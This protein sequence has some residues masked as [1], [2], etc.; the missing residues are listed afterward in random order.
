[1]IQGLGGVLLPGWKLETDSSSMVTLIYLRGP[2]REGRWNEFMVCLSEGG[3]TYWEAECKDD[4]QYFIEKEI[5]SPFN[6][7]W[8]PHQY[9]EWMIMN[10][11]LFLP[12]P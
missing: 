5:E 10:L 2:I 6:S 9:K 11:D 12:K 8:L 4:D 1:M 3:V 7:D